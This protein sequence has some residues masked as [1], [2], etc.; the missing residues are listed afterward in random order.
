MLISSLCMLII[1]PDDMIAGRLTS[2]MKLSD[3]PIKQG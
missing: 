1:S 3:D 2:F